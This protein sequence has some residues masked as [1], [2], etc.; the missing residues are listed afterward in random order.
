VPGGD[1]TVGNMHDSRALDT[2]YQA[3]CDSLG[4]AHVLFGWNLGNGVLAHF[5]RMLEKIVGLDKIY[6]WLFGEQFRA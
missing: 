3:G 1:G 2:A 5:S 6:F 4:D